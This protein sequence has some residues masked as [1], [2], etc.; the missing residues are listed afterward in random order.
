VVP[1]SRLNLAGERALAMRRGSRWK[2][3]LSLLLLI[4][5]LAGAPVSVRAQSPSDDPDDEEDAKPTPT[6]DLNIVFSEDGKAQVSSLVFGQPSAASEIKTVL[7]SSLGCTFDDKKQS[8]QGSSQFYGGSCEPSFQRTSM[9]REL[10]IAMAPLRKYALD[11]QIELLSLAV[12]LPDM[13]IRETEPP[14]QTPASPLRKMRPSLQRFVEL[15]R[16]YIW[17]TDDAIPDFVTVRFGISPKSVARAEYTLLGVLLLPLLL[18]FWMG[19]KAL[20]SEAQDKAVVWFTYMRYLQWTL[21][22]SLLGWWIAA[23]SLHL[24]QILQSLSA[25]TRIAPIWGYAVTPNIVNWFPPAIIWVLCFALSH[26]VQEKLRGLTWTRGELAMQGIYSFCASLLPLAL[27]L[28]GL[29]T[30]VR[31]SLRTGMLW[32][33]AA[34]AV[35]IIASRARQ[36]FLGMQ[37]QA[38][39][40]GDLRDRAFAMARQ[41]NVK[42]QQVYIIPSGKGQMANAFARKGNVISFTDFLLHRMTRREVNYVLG[43][44]MTHLKL[45]HPGK[46]AMAAVVSYFVAFTSTSFAEP[47]LH[48]SAVPRY[49]LIIAIVTL[50]PYFWSRR[51][52]YAADAGAVEVTGDPEAAIS[53]LFKLAQLNM[54]PIHWSNWSEKWLT[55]PSSLRRAQAIAR[56]AGIPLERVPEIAQV[57]AAADDHYVLPETVAAGAKVHSTHKK[58][59]GSLRVAF[60]MLALLIFTPASFALLANRFL[61]N[62]PFRIVL[63]LAGLAATIATYYASANFLPPM[64]L[65]SVVDSLKTKLA[66]EG[67]Q[68]DAWDGVFVGFS[69]AAA[70]RSY[71]QNTNWDLG[72]LF[73]R[74]D[75]LCYWG[76]ETKFSLRPDQITA[77]TLAPGMPSLLPPWR[78]YFAWKD[79]ELGTSGVFNIGCINGASTLRLREQ[80]SKLAERLKTWWKAP[81]TTRPL[82]GPLA[83][84]RSPQIGAVTRVAP[85]SIAS[86]GKVLKELYWTALFAIVGA[87]LCGLPFH[88]LAFLFSRLNES[89]GRITAIHSP[90]SGYYVVAVALAVRFIAMIPVLR[91]KDMA[92]VTISPSRAQASQVAATPGTQAQPAKVETDKVLLH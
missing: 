73:L 78:I 15:N 11:H 48:L 57:A 10:R 70:P 61:L 51:F 46:L 59:G 91:Y 66:Q 2:S 8:Y 87:I 32:M 60:T 86:P 43:H 82:P 92:I 3:S 83:A 81:A 67:I 69:P 27:F 74:S 33:V 41:L 16:P 37:P 14:I 47:F 1:A 7:E 89:L 18:I 65:P 19:R 21:N 39:T 62:S 29:S 80:S 50:G 52:E 58:Q 68:A 44:E 35:A 22:L 64:R 85:G 56:K 79:D 49:A 24:V 77:I 63:F 31:S 12:Y 71:E 36:K 45:G 23:D 34:F 38:L 13:E 40:T 30:M 5:T 90:G 72:C 26:P 17:H 76:E 28:T 84:L 88:L 4:L 53:A 25:G 75:R 20:S 6:L 54:L 55:H 42:L 9:V